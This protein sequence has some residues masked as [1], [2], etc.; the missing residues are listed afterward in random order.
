VARL[1][2]RATAETSGSAVSRPAIVLYVRYPH[3]IR[4]RQ[5]VGLSESCHKTQTYRSLRLIQRQR[6]CRRQAQC[7]TP[8]RVAFGYGCAS[9]RYGRVR[10]LHAGR[11]LGASSDVVLCPDGIP[12][13]ERRLDCCDLL[14]RSVI[15][16]GTTSAP[17]TPLTHKGTLL[18]LPGVPGKNQN[19]LMSHDVRPQD[20][21]I[22]K[23]PLR[24]RDHAIRVGDPDPAEAS[25]P[26]LPSC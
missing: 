16:D 22:V 4:Y 8:N 20:R 3:L 10:A 18:F 12:F 23:L 19:P 1:L 15:H 5:A 26:A 24:L 11:T 14:R 17:L 7:H 25:A 21:R 9:T 13:L 6:W 2:A